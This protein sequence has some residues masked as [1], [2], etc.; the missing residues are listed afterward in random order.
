MSGKKIKK[1][2]QKKIIEELSSSGVDLSSL[3]MK[4]GIKKTIIEN[5]L[6]KQEKP[7]DIEESNISKNKKESSEITG[8]NYEDQFVEL[9]LSESREEDNSNKR[10]SSN[11]KLETASLKFDNCELTI[12]GDISVSELISIIKILYSVC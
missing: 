1:E 3:A 9:S 12:G 7:L 8:S 10:V 2:D 5:W 6:E 11:H 4:Y